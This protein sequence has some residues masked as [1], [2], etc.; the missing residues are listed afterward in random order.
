MRKER[1]SA[2]QLADMINSQI[3]A[4]GVEVSVRR[5]HAYGWQPVDGGAEARKD[6]DKSVGGSAAP[7]VLRGPVRA[8]HHS[9][10]ASRVVPASAACAECR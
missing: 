5:D 7:V 8:D 10:L 6:G 1:V 4:R 9:L 2:T 3:G